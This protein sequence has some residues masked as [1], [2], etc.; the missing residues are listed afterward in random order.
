MLGQEY[1]DK[2]SNK[3]YTCTKVIHKTAYRAGE[4]DAE[5][6]WTVIG[7]DPFEVK[8]EIITIV[9]EQSVTSEYSQ[10]TPIGTVCMNRFP[11]TMDLIDGAKYIVCINNKNYEVTAKEVMGAVVIGD[12]FLYDAPVD[13]TG[14]PFFL[15]VMFE[16]PTQYVFVWKAEFGTTVT[17][18]IT[19]E[20][21][22]FEKIDYKFMPKGYPKIDMKDVFIVPEQT[23]SGGEYDNFWHSYVT[24]IAF[25]MA[26]S[27]DQSRRY[28][29]IINGKEYDDGGFGIM[30]QYTQ[31]N[32][33]TD[34]VNAQIRL[35]DDTLVN[36]TYYPLEGVGKIMYPDTMSE[37]T[38]A[39][40]EKQE[41]VTPMDSRFGSTL[42]VRFD[43][44]VGQDP[45]CNVT[46][47]K[48]R[49][50]YFNGTPIYAY[51][52]MDNNYNTKGL[53]MGH[54]DPQ[55]NL[56]YGGFFNFSTLFEAWSDG[57]FKRETYQ[58]DNNN[59]VYVTFETYKLTPQP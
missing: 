58:I 28:I 25:D 3:V 38:A 53:M 54:S 44:N 59:V 14:E 21:E 16:D 15:M 47:E 23:V 40:Y 8:K 26:L 19:C 18:S 2:D 46:F 37:I 32:Y 1:F 35:E 6:E 17:T 24:D 52:N 57:T 27:D 43:S 39:L 13:S 9:P 48:I 29:A 20:H 11:K 34:S 7:N 36:I 55:S 5:Y 56:E 4:A 31:V 12:P 22:I 30:V 51:V 49:E 45:T 50:A 33:V 10:D 41:V 42:V